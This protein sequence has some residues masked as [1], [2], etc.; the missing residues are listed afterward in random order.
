[1]TVHAVRARAAVFAACAVLSIALPAH[2]QLSASNLAIVQAGRALH[3][4]GPPRTDFYD[5]VDVAWRGEGFAAGGRFEQD[6]SSDDS[7][8][9]G[10]LAAYSEVT[11]R[12]AEWRGPHA[13]L[14][15]GNFH[16]LLGRGLLHRS[17]ELP[18]VVY[19]ESGSLTRFAASRDL[20]GVIAHGSAGPFTAQAFGGRPNEAVVSPALEN[21]GLERYRGMLQGA[22]LESALPYGASAGAAWT[23]YT[24]GDAPAHEGASGFASADLLRAFATRGWSAPAY[25]EYA[26]ADE[27]A[28]RWWQL[29]RGPESAHAMYGSLGVLW[30]AWT[31]NAEWKDYD[32]F[33]FGVND[34]PSLVREHSAPL[35]NRRTHVLDAEGEAGFQIEASAP[36]GAWGALTANLSRSDAPPGLRPVRFEERFVE[37]RIAPPGSGAWDATVFVSRGFDG[38]DFVGDRTT[39]GIG[40]RRAWHGWEGSADVEWQHSVSAPFAGAGV[41]STDRLIVLGLGRAKLGTASVSVTRT[42]DPLDL[43]YDEFGVATASHVTL[44]GVQCAAQLDDR[45]S[46]DLFLGR[47]RGGRACTSGTCYEVPSLDGAELRWVARY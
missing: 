44:V 45:H 40:L 19:D 21:I 39:R 4:E 25:F 17:W 5:R 42:D 10:R 31:L 47:R 3:A 7:P 30:G 46:L 38:F 32:H 37:A 8:S 26:Q 23:R 22:Q 13:S 2:A 20:D 6:R 9:F 11:Q 28:S 27:R 34:P 14:R 33:R 16:T 36:L 18:G 12:W 29:R 43:P 1:M 35:L 15:V 24:Y 41:P